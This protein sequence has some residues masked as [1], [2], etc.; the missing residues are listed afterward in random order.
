MLG[1]GRGCS[2]CSSSSDVRAG[3]LLGRY[4]KGGGFGVEF[5]GTAVGVADLDALAVKPALGLNFTRGRGETA[6][7]ASLG[8][9]EELLSET[10]A[11]VVCKS[12]ERKV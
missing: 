3:W 9:G 10:R 4:W 7:G 12:N 11:V 5:K 1:A 8:G 6:S 2:F